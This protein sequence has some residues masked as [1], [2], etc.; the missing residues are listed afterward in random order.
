[1][2]GSGPSVLILTHFQVRRWGIHARMFIEVCAASRPH[3]AEPSWCRRRRVVSARTSDVLLRVLSWRSQRDFFPGGALPLHGGAAAVAV[4]N[5]MR[6]SREF[7]Y[8]CVTMLQHH[9]NDEYVR[10]RLR[11][12][13]ARCAQ[14]R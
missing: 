7:D 2:D 3:A 13:E 14:L 6:Q 1:M 9:V 11:V 12:C 4:T 8:V 5:A 10:S